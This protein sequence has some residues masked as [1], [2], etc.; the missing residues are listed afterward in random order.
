MKE[1]TKIQKKG[2]PSI[3]I[4]S[5][6]TPGRKAILFCLAKEDKWKHP[7]DIWR[8]CK[9]EGITSSAGVLKAVKEME[10]LNLIDLDDFGTQEKN[11]YRCKLKEDVSVFKQI[12]SIFVNSENITQFMPLK[13][14]QRMIKGSVYDL[15]NEKYSISPDYNIEKMIKNALILSPTSLQHLLFNKPEVNVGVSMLVLS[16]KYY[17]EEDSDEIS[18]LIMG[19]FVSLLIDIEKYPEQKERIEEFLNTEENEGVIVDFLGFPYI[20][21]DI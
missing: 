15:I 3:K 1:K 14:T 7:A 10:K 2:Q 17:N 20:E 9:T 19:I 16:K 11:M 12:F 5:E 13:Y 6:L 18:K 21:D 8:D 4:K